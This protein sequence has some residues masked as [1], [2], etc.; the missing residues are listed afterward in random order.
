MKRTKIAIW[1]GSELVYNSIRDN[2][3]P[4]VSQIVTFIDSDKNKQ[5]L[6]FNGIPIIG[7]ED[8]NDED[9]E[10]ILI[11]AYSGMQSIIKELEGRIEH[12]KIQPYISPTLCEFN[13]GDLSGLEWDR[14]L[15]LY[16]RPEDTKNTIQEYI[17][18]YKQYDSITPFELTGKEWFYGK[19]LISHAGGGYVNGRPFENSNS[20]EALKGTI[21]HGYSLMECDVIR[22]PDGEWYLGHDYHTFYDA[23]TQAYTTISLYE[24]LI[25]LKQEPQII[26]LF[27]VKWADYDEYKCFVYTVKKILHETSDELKSQ[28]VFEV[29]DEETIQMAEGFQKIFTQY[30]NPEKYVHL[31]TVFLCGKYGIPAVAFKV[32]TLGHIKNQLKIYKE[33][34]I[35]SYVFHTDS[36]EEYSDIRNMGCYGIFTNF[37]WETTHLGVLRNLEVN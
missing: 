9:I 14:S 25:C 28:I 31:K 13:V 30:R 22:M 17:E 5:G 12:R 23:K 1:G 4:V 33:K 20:K 21:K 35:I 24:F 19:H 26:C 6:V 18:L 16:F 7:I 29:Y 27:D 11:A 32:N 36:P 2:I 8:L 34:N 10:Y 15:N 3:N 37:L